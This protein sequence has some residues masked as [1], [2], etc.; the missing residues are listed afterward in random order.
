MPTRRALII[1]GATAVLALSPTGAALADPGSGGCKAFGQSVSTLA[2]TVFPKGEFGENA[3]SAATSGP[4]AFPENVVQPE[5]DA[6][7]PE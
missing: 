2:N 5:Q 7:C 1:A 3:S 6:A 4:G